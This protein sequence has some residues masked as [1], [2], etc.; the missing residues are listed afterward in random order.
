M[1]PRELETAGLYDP[2]A[3]DAPARLALLDW[4]SEQGVTL[5][6]LIEAKRLGTP[7]SGL[8][9]DLALRGGERLTLAEIAA[10]TGMPPERIERINLAAGF[11]P[12]APDERA[13]GAEL[14]PTFTSFAVGEAFFGEA[15][16]LHFIR[17]LGSSLARVAEALVALFL[18][19]V[20][21][22]IVERGGDELALAQANLRAIQALEM[23]PDAVR[24]TVR[25]HLEVA[26][27]RLRAA[28]PDRG[29]LDTAHI[30]VGFVDLVG[31]TRLAREIDVRTLGA[32]VERFEALASDIVTAH[33][34][35][36]VKLIG[37]AVMFVAVD[38]KAACAIA[39]GLVERFADDPAVTPRGGLALGRALIRGGDYYGS[40]VN[41]AARVGELAVPREMLVT[42]EVAAAARGAAFRFE[43]A[44]R[45]ILKGFD[46]P[47]ALH[48]LTRA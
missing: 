24:A 9:G 17:V 33:D 30:T 35:R 4:L 45:R 5:A 27:R 14:V 34:G 13:F 32:L 25:T 28:R 11:P 2:A 26:I 47:V 3:P 18:A 46:A 40:A 29:A 43:P 42:D 39:L 38:P 36:V 21:A 10:R 6:D 41:L 15:S 23:V 20:E 1:T 16:M 22:P 48:A 12:V 8:A 19:K 37:D 44:G 31:Y 7:L